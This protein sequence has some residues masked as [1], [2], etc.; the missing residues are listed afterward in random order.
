MKA[1]TI[2]KREVKEIVKKKTFII[3]TILTP[4][5]FIAMIFLP[6][7]IMGKVAKT[8]AKIMVID[9]TNDVFDK[10]KSELTKDKHLSSED[11]KKSMKDSMT[12]DANQMAKGIVKFH[13]KK[14][15]IQKKD[16]KKTEESLK[17]KIENKE[18]YGYLIIP[19]NFYENR[20]V[21]FKAKNVANMAMIGSMNTS[22]RKIATRKLLTE[23]DFPEEKI[24]DLTKN[25]EITTLKIEKGKEKK[26]SFLGEYM[27]SVVLV[28]LLFTIIMAYG[29][30]I[31]RGILEEKNVRMIEI[32][33]S[34]VDSFTLFLGKI[35]GVGLAGLL[36]VGI[37]IFMLLIG[38][39]YFTSFLPAEFA[40]V[41]ID[42][43]I[44]ISFAIFFILGYF[45]YS[46]LF[47]VAGAVTNTDREAQQFLQPIMF[48]LIIPFILAF[49]TVQNPDNIVIIILSFFPFFTPILMFVRTAFSNPPLYQLILSIT[50]LGLSVLGM[51]FISSKLFRIGILSY[52]KRP[53]L[54]DLIMWLKVR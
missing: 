47:A 52:G 50:I 13:L 8:E 9:F 48:I 35:V 22:L 37:W 29:Q 25:I 43:L 49:S 39:L 31:M 44:Y 51:I 7:L 46:T 12:G 17:K 30:I 42:P 16:L 15:N 32:I 53:K 14:I 40:A 19:E 23:E 10:L 28:T 38:Y 18:I 36:Q 21:I 24:E 41:S 26:S 33:L 6:A 4:V 3:G 1:K 34:S 2:I 5:I 27:F 45:L 11:I 54:K 20:K